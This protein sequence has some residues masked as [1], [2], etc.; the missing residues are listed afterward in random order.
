MND[1]LA[2][3]LLGLRAGMQLQAQRAQDQ[4]A[5]FE[6][7][8]AQMDEALLFAGPERELLEAKVAEVC[9]RPRSP[10]VRAHHER[11]LHASHLRVARRTQLE[12]INS[13]A[14]TEMAIMDKHLEQLRGKG[15]TAAKRLRVRSEGH[16]IE[17]KRTGE[18]LSRAQEA[19]EALNEYYKLLSSDTT[20]SFV[21]VR[22]TPTPRNLFC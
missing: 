11:Y 16:R 3:Q 20:R 21:K 5:V 15:E 13:D 6:L 19:N 9:V 8:E 7:R 18:K 14:A 22:P 1:G 4:I 17:K 2:Q 12:A 10:L